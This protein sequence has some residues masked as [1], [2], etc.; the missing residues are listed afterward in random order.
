MTDLIDRAA[1]ETDAYIADC[2]RRHRKPPETPDEDES[3]R[4]CLGCGQLIDLRRLEKTPGAVRCVPCETKREKH[5][6]RG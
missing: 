5:G 3:G 4:Y 6:N 2:I 1:V